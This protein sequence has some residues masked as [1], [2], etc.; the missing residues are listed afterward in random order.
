[1]AETPLTY[2]PTERFDN[3]NW[4]F[5]NHFK[6]AIQ[7]LP[8]LTFF[9]QSIQVPSITTQSIKRGTPFVAIKEVA[10]HLTYASFEVNYLIDSQMKTYTSLLWWLQGY[11]FPHSYQEVVD[12]RALRAQRLAHP[13][14]QV[15]EVEKTHGL[16]TI[17]QPDTDKIIA[18]IH[19]LDMFPT[20][21]SALEFNTT[22]PDAPALRATVTFDCTLFDVVPLFS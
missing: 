3:T 6:F 22:D 12:F 13:V 15:R 10:D 7:A 11:G 19:Y 2:N 18:E 5:G 9:A 16:L 20:A 1:M 21:L 14:T 17:L 8:D 4:L